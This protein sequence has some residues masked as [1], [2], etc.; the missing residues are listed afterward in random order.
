MHAHG[1]SL[2]SPL[3]VRCLVLRIA[4]LRLIEHV[5]RSVTSQGVQLHLAHPTWLSDIL[6]YRMVTHGVAA[7]L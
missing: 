5:D 4:R 3:T 2:H 1:D 6:L 7:W